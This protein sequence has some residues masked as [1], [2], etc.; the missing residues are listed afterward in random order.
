MPKLNFLRRFT[1]R[2]AAAGLTA[3]LAATGLAVL[4]SV[5]SASHSQLSMIEDY[6]TLNP[7]PAGADN[8]LLQYR[9]LGA[10]T[11][12][13]IVPWAA[14]AP[15][16]TRTRKPSFNATDPNAYSA[17]DWAPFDN[18][19]R[20]ANA[21]GL[22]VDLTVAGGAPR[23][24]EASAPAGHPGESLVNLAWKPNAADYG[25]F[26][27]AI[28][29]RYDGHFTPRGQS[30][31]LP[32]VRFWAIFNEPN[33]GYDLGPQAVDGSRVAY[34]PM[35]Y[36]SLV[37]AGWSALQAT[38]H[39]RDTILIGEL[40][41]RGQSGPPSAHA[42]QGYPGNY[43]QTKPLIFIR[44]LYCVDSNYRQ[45]RG[46]AARSVGCPTSAA[47]S[48]RFRTQNPGLFSA[49]GFGDHPYPGN[50]SPV[51]DGRSDPDFAAFPDL[52]NMERVLDRVNG[53]YGSG[54]HYS[55][56]NDEYGYITDPPNRTR[57]AITGGHYVSPATAA[58]YINWAEYLSWRSPRIATSMQYLLTDPPQNLGVYSGFT[59]GIETST[60]KPKANYD[61]YRLPLYM[62]NT[63]F[64]HRS[65]IEV[66]GDARP[67]PFMSS[68][69]KGKQSVAIQLNG[70]TLKTVTV[71]G[72]TG[73]F[74][75]RMK[76]P[77]SGFV[78]L[79]YT[80]P[81]T[82]PFLAPGVA[83]KTVFSRNVGIKVH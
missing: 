67:A 36:R 69:G 64:S 33:F 58:Y 63:S 25:Q 32:A 11:I 61:A 55:I 78:R 16:A 21:L 39:G 73:Y 28:G 72:S 29:T 37:N 17:A 56:Y 77:K 13:V 7:N 20:E 52:G 60:G 9:M 19:V 24:A 53:I 43:S 79:A 35:A 3:A 27:R 30:S 40:A 42:P 47:G 41:A 75:I 70:R 23:W 26:V 74:D 1:G 76:F 22:K 50:L 4:P 51:A 14:I 57:V 45:L 5:A 49:S 12:R 82:D 59:S 6:G 8:T 46:G 80:Y 68:D 66:W 34:A 48:R 31:A 65:N 54:K 18:A 83:G 44:Y 62:P 71:T 81:K 10:N 38:G 15:G 2:L